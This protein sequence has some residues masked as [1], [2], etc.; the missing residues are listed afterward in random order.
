MVGTTPPKKVSAQLGERKKRAA[1]SQTNASNPTA[2][3]GTNAA[4]AAANGQR[5]SRRRP[6]NTTTKCS[7][8][9]A[10]SGEVAT[11]IQRH[12][13]VPEMSKASAARFH[14]NKAMQ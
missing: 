14:E 13:M 2:Q 11:S 3:S 7:A 6:T 1:G 4:Y 5:S 8:S 10:L 12:W 9:G